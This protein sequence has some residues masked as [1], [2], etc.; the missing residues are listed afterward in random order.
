M[1]SV[2]T[3]LAWLIPCV[4]IVLAFVAYRV[5]VIRTR[6]PSLPTYLQG[7][8]FARTKSFIPGSSPA[9]PKE[10]P[11][12]IAPGVY[13]VPAPTAAL[14]IR[15]ETRIDMPN[16]QQPAMTSITPVVQTFTPVSGGDKASISSGDKASIY[17]GDKA[18]ISSESI[19]TKNEGR[20]PPSPA[21]TR[22][23]AMK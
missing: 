22:L 8:I 13:T 4:L 20:I 9:E 7:N 18:S 11:Q 5:Y 21:I 12:S 17:G 2:T 3:L 23:L 15:N 1:S 10:Q 14:P 6:G 19:E 16:Q